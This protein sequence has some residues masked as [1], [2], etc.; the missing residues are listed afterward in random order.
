MIRTFSRGRRQSFCYDTMRGVQSRRS[1]MIKVYLIS[2]Y[3]K[4]YDGEY[5]GIM[6]PAVSATS[7]LITATYLAGKIPV[8]LNR[9][10]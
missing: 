2:Q 7:M 6:L 1:Y 10:Q 9:T 3:I 5:I 4:K 8:M